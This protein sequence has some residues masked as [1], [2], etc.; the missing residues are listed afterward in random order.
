VSATEW[1]NVATE[2]TA[3]SVS[4]PTA[5]PPKSPAPEQKIPNG[6]DARLRFTFHTAFDWICPLVI[7]NCSIMRFMHFLLSFFIRRI[8]R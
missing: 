2:P 5:E 7:L 1:R 3:S 6:S 4:E 8:G